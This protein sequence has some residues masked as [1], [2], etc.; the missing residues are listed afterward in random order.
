MCST[1]SEK[2]YLLDNMENLTMDHSVLLI[3]ESATLP[4]PKLSLQKFREKKEAHYS[5][6]TEG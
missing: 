2:G 1:I 4:V 5:R 6:Y 3:Y